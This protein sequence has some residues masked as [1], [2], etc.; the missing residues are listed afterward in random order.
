MPPSRGKII[1]D[2]LIYNDPTD[3]NNPDQRVFDYTKNDSNLSF[4]ETDDK[5]TT[6]AATTTLS[7]QL[8]SA[9]VRYFYLESNQTLTV[10]LNGDTSSNYQVVPDSAAKANGVFYIK[11]AITSIDL[12]NPGTLDA[13]TL[14]F[15]AR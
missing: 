3:T 12:V 15:W 2:F 9:G 6:I 7:V 11:S 5:N 1:F 14:Y 8:P 4:V 10:R 13:D